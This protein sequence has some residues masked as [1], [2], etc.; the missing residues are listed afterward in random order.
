M[1]DV[2]KV[3]VN[4]ATLDEL[5]SV[6][7]IG[8]ALAKRIIDRRPFSNLD[9][10][11]RV[12]G[13]GENSLENLK[14]VLTTQE[15]EL[16]A[17]FQSF[18]DSIRDETKSE[19]M[20]SEGVFEEDQQ[21]LLEEDLGEGSRLDRVINEAFVEPENDDNQVIDETFLMPEATAENEQAK[22]FD[23][24]E[25]EAEVEIIEPDPTP[26]Q[27]VEIGSKISE[28][29]IDSPDDGPGKVEEVDSVKPSASEKPVEAISKEEVTPHKIDDQIQPEKSS[30]DVAISRSQ[31]I[32]SLIGTAIFS[33]LL[34]IL[35]TLGILS[36]T[37]GGLKYATVSEASRLENQITILN[38]LTS[39]MQTDMQGIRTRLDA[40]ETVAGRVSVLEGRADSMEADLGTIQ[41]T[42]KEISE[43]LTTIQDNIVAL[44]ESAKKSE[45]FRSGLYQLLISID[46]QA[47]EGE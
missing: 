17:D 24:D 11:T 34:T 26:E 1:S 27:D 37:N 36:A 44:Q 3:N 35:I 22:D 16:S 41:T 30:S 45:D 21:S 8:P 42:V 47:Q 20:I 5:T 29:E 23:D 9:D 6:P 18:V 14:P 33:I 15:T 38:D 46:G 40:L 32:W 10:L 2:K 12:S 28:I 13:I 7:G 31:L 4:T 39:T 19:S 25:V 43:T